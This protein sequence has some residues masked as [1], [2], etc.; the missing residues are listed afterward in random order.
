MSIQSIKDSKRLR[1]EGRRLGRAGMSQRV[2]EL[3]ADYMSKY[4][5]GHYIEAI[6]LAGRLHAISLASRCDGYWHEKSGMGFRNEI[7]AICKFK[8]E[9]VEV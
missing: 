3:V 5:D 6:S 9:T 7:F 2:H 1:E 8:P 4:P